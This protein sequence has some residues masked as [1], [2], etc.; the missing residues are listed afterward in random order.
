MMVRIHTLPQFFSSI[1]SKGD[2]VIVYKI[3]PRKK[4]LQSD[5]QSV[6]VRDEYSSWFNT[7]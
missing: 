5:K 2:L 7:Y 3:Y 4:Y 6:T 1:F